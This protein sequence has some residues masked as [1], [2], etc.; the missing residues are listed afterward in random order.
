MDNQYSMQQLCCKIQAF[1]DLFEVYGDEIHRDICRVERSA[2]SKEDGPPEELAAELRYL[3]GWKDL[4]NE[5]S[6][7]FH[8]LFGKILAGNDYE[9]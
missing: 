1:Y 2:L 6:G 9:E 3:N 4:G 8:E 5:L 7:K